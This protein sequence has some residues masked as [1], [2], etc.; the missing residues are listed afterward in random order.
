MLTQGG[1]WIRLL[2]KS[3]TGDSTKKLQNTAQ[4]FDRNQGKKLS[5]SGMICCKPLSHDSNF[6]RKNKKTKKMR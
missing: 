5:T 1:Y 4:P 6:E 3:A 2:R